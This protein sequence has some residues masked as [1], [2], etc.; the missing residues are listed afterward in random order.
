MFVRP[1]VKLKEATIQGNDLVLVYSEPVALG[2][3]TIYIDGDKLTT[4]ITDVAGNLTVAAESVIT[5]DIT[6]LKKGTH[7]IAVVGT[8]DLNGNIITPNATELAFTKKDATDITLTKPVIVSMEQVSDNGFKVVF[9][10]TKVTPVDVSSKVLSIKNAAHDGTKFVDLDVAAA[11]IHAEEVDVNNDGKNDHTEWYVTVPAVKGLGAKDGTELVYNGA[12]TM[13]KDIVVDKDAYFN[14]GDLTGTAAT[15][16]SSEPAGDEKTLSVT[17][18]KD[19][20]APVIANEAKDITHAND[21]IGIAFTDGP[22]STNVYNGEVELPSSVKKATVKFVDKKGVTHEQEITPVISSTKTLD[23]RTIVDLKVTNPDM[24]NN[25]KLVDGAYTIVLPDGFVLDTVEDVSTTP[26]MAEDYLLV[27]GQNPF[28]KRTVTYTVE[29]KENV[30]G[31]PATTKGLIN[32]KVDIDNASTMTDVQTD[33]D[34]ILKD[35]QIA[36]VFDGDVDPKTATVKSNY[37]LN[38]KALGSNDT[39]EFRRIDLSANYGDANA[40]V[41]VITLA[42]ETVKYSGSYDF[43][44]SGVANRLGNR[45]L[46][47]E[48][49]V[50]LADNTAPVAESITIEDSNKV[51]VKFSE[52]VELDATYD[53]YNNFKVT[54]NGQTLSVIGIDGDGTNELTLTLSDNFI[55]AG[56][57]LD[58]PATVVVKLEGNGD[59]FI[60]DIAGNKLAT[61]TITKR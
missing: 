30:V 44:V 53:A 1:T 39:V 50:E 32:S 37:K 48:D 11:D 47:V 16:D 9:N 18:T 45:M 51:I 17:F 2:T 10:T 33:L 55:E 19:T 26:G 21:T 46:A 58:V 15:K 40:Q 54:V 24:L 56:E 43:D 57:S 23:G 42:N 14:D 59:M 20:K 22:F 60:T 29:D 8:Q 36:I 12:N 3:S 34:G 49:K 52:K 31:V 13:K 6:S 38:G 41:V 27:E 7:K 28:V 35:N 4:G 25:T 61:G 5:V